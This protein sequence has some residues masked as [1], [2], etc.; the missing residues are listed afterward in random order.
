[1]RD[2]SLV[3][4]EISYDTKFQVCMCHVQIYIIY[5]NTL[6]HTETDRH[7]GRLFHFYFSQGKEMGSCKAVYSS[8]TF[9]YLDSLADYF[10]HLEGT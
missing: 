9:L 8:K 10:L 3:R 1:M 6:A 7:K 2:I 5:T 4:G